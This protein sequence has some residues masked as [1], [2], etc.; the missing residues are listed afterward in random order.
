[1]KIS[2]ETKVGALTA[3]SITLLI[4]GFNFLKGKNLFNKKATM[5]VTFSKVE[6]LNIAD[7]IKINGLR[8]GAVESIDEMDA[9]LTKVAVAFHL[10]R[11]INI[12]KDS[13]AKIVATPLGS[14]AITINLGSGKT[15]LL[16]GDTLMGQDTKGLIDDIKTSLQPT[17]DNVNNTLVSLDSTIKRI[18][19]VFN[20]NAK[21]DIGSI[22]LELAT[23]TNEL[24][25]LLAPGKGNLALSLEN[26]NGFTSNLKSNNDSITTIVNN[27][28][29]LSNNLASVDISNTV[30]SIEK[31]T[32]NLT[33]IL[34]DLRA[35][36]GS[37]GK[38]ASDETLYKTLNSTANSLNVLLQD[39][40]MHP[41]RYV[42]VSV[43]GKKDN[44]TPLMTALPDSLTKQN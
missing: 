1:M 20:E 35:G 6:G 33:G 5:Y 38:L 39:L 18:G 12:P 26:I 27:L 9:D 24:N 31:A 34:Q 22:L 25:K 15:F 30:Q 3:V 37:L 14:T 36:K 44:S 8:V 42:Q 4:L 10:T 23:T 29:K 19:G 32:N 7:A 13:Y 28:A 41:K 2:N 40:R 43:F 11:H 21:Q 16:D 17:I